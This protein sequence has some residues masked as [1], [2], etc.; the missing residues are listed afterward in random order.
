MTAPKLI[1]E[2]HFGDVR[3]MLGDIQAMLAI[4]NLKWTDVVYVQTFSD[5]G[6]YARILRLWEETLTDGSK[7]YNLHI[8]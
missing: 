1:A 7:V 8:L 4:A 3:A 2:R 6:G 5:D